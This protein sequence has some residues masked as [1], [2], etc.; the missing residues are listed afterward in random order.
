M[1]KFKYL[2][3]LLSL[4]FL[5]SCESLYDNLETVDVYLDNKTTEY[6]LG[7]TI[8]VI[9]KGVIDISVYSNANIL[10]SLQKMNESGRYEPAK[11][12][13]LKTSIDSSELTAGDVNEFYSF[14]VEDSGE[15]RFIINIFAYKYTSGNSQL[16]TSSFSKNLD[17][18]VK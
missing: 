13:D 9:I 16:T 17:F 11:R 18:T 7:D 8:T 4:I 15:Y 5:T 6:A 2:L 10:C 12:I 14:K 3:I 1:K